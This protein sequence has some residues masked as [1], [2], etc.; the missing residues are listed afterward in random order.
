MLCARAEVDREAIETRRTKDRER[1]AARRNVTSRDTADVTDETLPLDKSPQTPKIKPQPAHT[2]ETHARGPIFACPEGVDRQHW[3]D[4]LA[5]RKR[6]GL[7][8]TVT[9]YQGQLKAISD[10]A[11]DE[12]PPGRLVEFA[13]SRGWGSINNPRDSGNGHGRRNGIDRMAGNHR[14]SASGRGTTIDAAL[15]FIADGEPH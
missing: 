12:W 4:F 13:A 3:S 10:L 11:D 5:N 9:A 15:A 2:H 6:K 8:S 1:Q 7:A 14:G